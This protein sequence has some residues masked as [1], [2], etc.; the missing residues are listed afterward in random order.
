MNYN[1]FIAP[2]ILTQQCSSKQIYTDD[3]SHMNFHYDYTKEHY[4]YKPGSMTVQSP[5]T[6]I[7][8]EYTGAGHHTTLPLTDS[9]PV[10]T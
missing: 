7:G 6:S 1:P 5:I 8:R 10:F 9:G 2:D 4:E 3:S